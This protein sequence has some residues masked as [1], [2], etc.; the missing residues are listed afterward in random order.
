MCHTKSNFTTVPAEQGKRPPPASAAIGA[1]LQ[2]E[3]AATMPWIIQ[4]RSDTE[5]AIGA[6]KMLESH[7]TDLLAASL[8]GNRHDVEYL[9]RAPG[10][11]RRIYAHCI[12][13]LTAQ[14]SAD[15]RVIAGIRNQFCHT[16]PAPTFKSDEVAGP[17][18]CL[19][20]FHELRS[21]GLDIRAI[22]V[23]SAFDLARRLNRRLVSVKRIREVPA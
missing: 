6:A 18:G 8:L 9:L 5:I 15:L 12:G 20:S 13:L 3:A 2:D 21:A 16:I 17:A 1:T 10:K 4:A 11:T 22:F 23:R 7:V 19:S 14:E